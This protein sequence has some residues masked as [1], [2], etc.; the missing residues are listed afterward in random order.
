MK[1]KNLPCLG[2]LQAFS[3]SFYIGLISVFFTY[4]APNLPSHPF[5]IG[6]IMLTLLV[7][8]AAVTGSL[9]F[10]YPVYLILNKQT[11]EGV[12][13]FAYTLLFLVV[14]LAILISLF[15]LFS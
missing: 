14:I 2:L 12:S 4:V 5:V 6:M 10:G 7:F 11:K 8:S 9:V 15:S 3:V 1:C 13:I